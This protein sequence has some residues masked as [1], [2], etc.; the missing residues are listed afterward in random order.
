M[1]YQYFGH[2][3]LA[4]IPV[5]GLAGDARAD[6]RRVL[7]TDVG[8]FFESVNPLPGYVL[9]GSPLRR[10][11]LDFGGFGG[12]GLMTNHAEIQARKAGLRTSFGELMAIQ[13]FHS[14]REM[15]PVAESDRLGGRSAADPIP[16]LLEPR[17]NL[18]L[19]LSLTSRF[20]LRAWVGSSPTGHDRPHEEGTE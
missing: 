7:E 16:D 19:G 4:H 6:V 3:E 10:H 12:D 18:L 2:G 14:D 17:T 15:L 1:V 9:A 8:V 13:A 20:R 5:A 11:L